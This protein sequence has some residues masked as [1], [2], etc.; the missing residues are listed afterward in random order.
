LVDGPSTDGVRITPKV[1]AV[2][3]PAFGSLFESALRSDGEATL[4]TDD[5]LVSPTPRSWILEIQAKDKLD[6]VRQVNA[7]GV[8]ALN[9]AVKPLIDGRPFG[10]VLGV[11]IMEQ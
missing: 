5:P 7:I 11:S 10:W 9:I 3:R 8:R 4:G 1:D 6:A 2:S